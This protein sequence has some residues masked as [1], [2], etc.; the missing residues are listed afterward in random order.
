MK[1][2]K[3]I[4]TAALV[5]ILLAACMST[6]TGRDKM[7]GQVDVFGV[8]L[9]SDVD[10]K[11][12]NGVAATEEP[13]IRGYDRSFDALD[14]TIGYGFDK[15]IRK[16]T[17]RNINTSLFGIKPGMSFEEGKKM[18]LQAGFVEDVPPFAFKLKRYSFSFLVDSN[19]K[20][21]GLTL[22]SLD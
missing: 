19:N 11:K 12:I 5:T 6:S 1:L 9:F 2:L 21:F 3:S 18:I 14:L 13:C 8:E 16:I 20:I 7:T 22:E 4:L 17:T 15:K 10:Y